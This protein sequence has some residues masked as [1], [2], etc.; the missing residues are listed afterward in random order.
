MLEWVW[1]YWNTHILLVG[2]YIVSTN[3]INNLALF[4]K[5]EMG[6]PYDPAKQSLE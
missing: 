5:V 4:S 6:K 2:V 3:L 1:I